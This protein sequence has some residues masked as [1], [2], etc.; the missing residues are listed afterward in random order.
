MKNYENCKDCK[1]CERCKEYKRIILRILCVIFMTSVLLFI[2]RNASLSSIQSII[3][4]RIQNESPEQ[5]DI[6]KRLK[7]FRVE[8]EDIRCLTINLFQCTRCTRKTTQ[9]T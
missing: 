4:P 9:S 8:A 5:N 7:P 2:S 3:P 6:Q 1:N